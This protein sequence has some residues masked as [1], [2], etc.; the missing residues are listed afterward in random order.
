MVED[1]FAWLIL[2]GQQ[3]YPLS[4][5]CYMLLARSTRKNNYHEFLKQNLT[6][7]LWLP[8][9]AEEEVNQ[10][11]DD[12]SLYQHLYGSMDV[13]VKEK[14]Q[15]NFEELGGVPRYVLKNEKMVQGKLLFQ[16]AVEQLSAE[17]C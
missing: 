9:W 16:L 3:P 1:P 10:F 15:A 13:P 2:D 12:F 7:L 5:G 14:V 4:Y 8:V 6:R 11:C 17:L